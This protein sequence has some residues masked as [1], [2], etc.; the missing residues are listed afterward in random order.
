VTTACL[1]GTPGLGPAAGKLNWRPDRCG[2][3]DRVSQAGFRLVQERGLQ[4]GGFVHAVTALPGGC[5]GFPKL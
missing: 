2:I 3:F 1:T 4:L 5:V